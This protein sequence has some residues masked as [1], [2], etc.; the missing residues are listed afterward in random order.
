ML[1]SRGTGVWEF[2]AAPPRAESRLLLEILSHEVIDFRIAGNTW[3]DDS[4]VIEALRGGLISKRPG[5][6]GEGGFAG[7]GAFFADMYAD[8]LIVG[9]GLL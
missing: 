9:E 3:A 4:E 5:S 1:S 7:T 2:G 8:G 6:F